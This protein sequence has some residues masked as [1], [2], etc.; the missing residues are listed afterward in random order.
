MRIL[1]LGGT[2]AMG[3][4]LASILCNNN[5]DVFVTTRS[6]RK[7]DN[8]KLCYITGNAHDLSFLNSILEGSRNNFDAIV[9]F[10]HYSTKEFSER[11]LYLLNH[12]EHYLYLSSARVYA[13]SKNPITE[14]SPRLLDVCKDESYL[15]T[16]DYALAKARQ[17]DFLI[18]SG[19][20]NYTIIRPF[21]TFS[22]QRLQLGV[23][24]K[25][26]WL[27]RVFKGKPIVFSKDIAE[28]LTTLTYGFDVSK[29]IAGLVGNEKAKGEI[30]HIATD[31]SIKWV[32]IAQL[33]Q[34]VLEKHFKREIKLLYADKCFFLDGFTSQ[35]AVKYSRY[36]DYRFDNSKIC[37]VVPGITFVDT[38]ECLEHCLKEFL[39]RPKFKTIQPYIQARMDRESCTLLP[40]SAWHSNKDKLRYLFY[41][42]APISLIK[43]KLNQ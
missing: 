23:F 40:L 4:H 25:E 18:N 15:S 39:F 37:S 21:I 7:S 8:H 9:D 12:T 24:E 3:V 20:C 30:F 42:F 31:K 32:E 11:Y 5:H 34:R 36:F 33:Y 29:A 16:D 2:G 26:D 13:E 19:Y 43:S 38:I 28:H 22:E 35:W 6:E 14:E 1:L 27:S 41:R 17:E 10:M